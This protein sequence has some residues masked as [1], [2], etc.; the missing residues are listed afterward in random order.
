MK[1]QEISGDLIVAS[2]NGEFDVIAHGC[3]CFCLQDAGI[4]RQMSRTFPT[5]KTEL[6]NDYY[7]GCIDKLGCIDSV[8][9]LRLHNSH[10]FISADT[11]T[12]T[13]HMVDWN[14]PALSVVNAYTQYEPGSNTDY[15]ALALCMT[16]INHT[17]KGK[18]I[19]LPRIGCGIGGASWH[20]V[21]N[22]IRHKL[23]DCNVTIM[24]L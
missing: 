8:R 22:I 9:V 11:Y 5:K 23:Q 2:I 20:K 15:D 14:F 16:K 7:K 10:H 13:K 24:I 21:S 1:Y 6:E 19:G 17:F 4:A 3:N 12:V 18:H